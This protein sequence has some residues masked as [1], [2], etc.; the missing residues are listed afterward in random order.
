[1]MPYKGYKATTI[2]KLVYTTWIFR[3]ILP[4]EIT[5]DLGGQFLCQKFTN[6]LIEAEYGIKT[7]LSY[8][9]NP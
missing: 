8:L 6:R 5:Y 3:Y 9:V 7:K 2:G 4:V 1:M